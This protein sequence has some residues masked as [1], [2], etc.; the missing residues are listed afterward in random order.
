MDHVVK[1]PL[2]FLCQGKK[3][4]KWD[5]MVSFVEKCTLEG[6]K[7][8]KPRAALIANLTI[9]SFCVD[10]TMT[11]LQKDSRQEIRVMNGSK[12]EKTNLLEIVFH[13]VRK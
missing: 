1:F 6:L 10:K 5:L 8:T 13:N 3:K 4:K 9:I 11:I 12:K 7:E 2:L